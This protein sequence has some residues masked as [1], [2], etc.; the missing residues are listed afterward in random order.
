LEEGHVQVSRAPIF[1]QKWV[2]L[3]LWDMALGHSLR[4]ADD[5]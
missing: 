1:R 5:W 4:D 3:T 2:G